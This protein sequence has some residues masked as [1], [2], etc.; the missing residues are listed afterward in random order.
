MSAKVTQING[1]A[2]RFYNVDGE[3]FPS[4]THILSAINKPALVPWAA[5]IEREAVS[6][7]AAS[8]YSEV[9]AA[10]QQYP[11]SWFAAALAAKLGTVKAHERTLARAGDIGT[12]IH[13][14]IEWLLRTALGA[15]AGPK[16]AI[17]APALIGVEAFKTWATRVKLKPVL[18][19]RIVYSKRHKFAGT[20]DVLA[21]VDGELVT[22][23]FKSG[24]K[25][26]QEAH[27]QAAA[28]GA[29]L[30]EMGYTT[31]A[32][33]LI[34]R[35]PK[36]ADDPGVEVLEVPDAPALVPVFLATRALWEWHHASEAAYKARTSKPRA[37]KVETLPALPRI[38]AVQKIAGAR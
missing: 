5:K 1:P 30:E 12:E 38:V 8:L 18:V 15:E 26:Y 21:R 17:S 16:P 11:A 10:R 32:R 14:A 20:L 13:L 9:S 19:E 22:I 4:V 25:I 28:Y 2:G 7:A 33:A 34:V 6:A 24:K 31:P 37:A 36:V 27:L 23:D 35:L 29:A 3:L